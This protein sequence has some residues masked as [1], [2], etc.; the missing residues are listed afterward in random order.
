M[1]NDKNQWLMCDNS[2]SG[3]N[4]IKLRWIH[5]ASILLVHLPFGIVMIMS[6]LT[7]S[8][9]YLLFVKKFER[10]YGTVIST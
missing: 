9:F 2:K 1:A 8:K 3:W 4:A 10:F 5:I 6:A 7:L